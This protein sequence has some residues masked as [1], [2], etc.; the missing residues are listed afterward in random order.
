MYRHVDQWNTIRGPD[1][2]PHIISLFSTNLQR[3]SNGEMIV[4]STNSAATVGDL[5]SKT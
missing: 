1:I 3:N 4:F 5:Y 2:D